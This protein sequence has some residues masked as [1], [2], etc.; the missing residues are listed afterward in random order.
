M[1][2]LI[3]LFNGLADAVILSRISPCG[4]EYILELRGGILL[5]G[6]LQ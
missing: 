2:M 4:Y 1:G 5:D 6:Y 3:T